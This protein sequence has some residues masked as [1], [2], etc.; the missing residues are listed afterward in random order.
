MVPL[1]AKVVPS[2][3]SQ[4]QRR[5]KPMPLRAFQ[6]DRPTEIPEEESDS[7]AAAILDWSLNTTL[8]TLNLSG[9]C[10]GLEKPRVSARTT[11]AVG[12]WGSLLR[13]VTGN[14]RPLALN[15]SRNGI[16][17]DVEGSGGGER[18]WPLTVLLE[19]AACTTLT[20]L[21]L[22]SNE[23]TPEEGRLIARAVCARCSEQA[24]PRES[25][26]SNSSVRDDASVREGS[27]REG[28]V[29]EGSVRGD[30]DAGRGRSGGRKAGGLSLCG[31]P[32]SACYDRATTRL[33]LYN[34]SLG[35]ADAA[36]LTEVPPRRAARGR[37]LAGIGGWERFRPLSR[38]PWPASVRAAVFAAA[39]R[40]CGVARGPPRLRRAQ[41]R[42]PGPPQGGL[43][44]GGWVGQVLLRA[45]CGVWLTCLDL[46]RNG[47]GGDGC[48]LLS[49]ALN[50]LQSLEILQAPSAR[51][52]APS[53]PPSQPPARPPTHTNMRARAGDR[54]GG[55]PCATR[56]CPRRGPHPRGGP[57]V[58]ALRRRR[59]G[60]GPLRGGDAC[61][62]VPCAALFIRV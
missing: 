9:L 56:P 16:R 38:Q 14:A 18:A 50:V 44:D 4:P 20:D 13:F 3:S 60:G 42:Q 36:M 29:R 32:V 57:A 37:R 46:N 15:L 8:T 11:G 28:S 25:S 24:P 26:A 39:H 30:A 23:L 21:D 33:N 35:P 45:P 59:Q 10:L 41:A 34:E 40:P 2:T 19:L 58:P 53:H 27:V 43:T 12:N 17:G 55:S 1:P 22:R 31:I 54:A 52:R 7:L 48:R 47:L 61:L 49:G 5:L 62:R 51:L 6:P